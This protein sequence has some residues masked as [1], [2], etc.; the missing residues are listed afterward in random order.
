[1]ALDSRRSRSRRPRPVQGR[2]RELTRLAALPHSAPRVRVVAASCAAAV[3]TRPAAVCA[4]AAA[5][6]PR[7][8]RLWLSVGA[9]AL[10]AFVLVMMET[11]PGGLLPQIAGGLHI[12]VSPGQGH[13]RQTTMAN[14]G[15]GRIPAAA[16]L[17]GA[18]PAG[19]TA[20]RRR[21]GQLRQPADRPAVDLRMR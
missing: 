15:N 11:M 21:R 7:I 6:E 4:E 1:M 2:A 19:L 17:D 20:A 9:V 12:D 3:P 16:G 18:R 14:A 5:A 13:R 10:G 8:R